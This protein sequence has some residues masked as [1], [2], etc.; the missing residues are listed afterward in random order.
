M[1]SQIK[2]GELDCPIDYF[3]YSQEQKEA[4]CNEILDMML[5]ML[6]RELRPEINRMDALDMVLESSIIT[7]Q[8]CEKYEV[9]ALLTD[10]RNLINE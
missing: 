5:H 9:C 3:E 6:D 1:K 8:K 10:I 4:L 2:I 7:N